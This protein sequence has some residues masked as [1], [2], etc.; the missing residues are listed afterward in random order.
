[1]IWLQLHSFPGI[2]SHLITIFFL[3]YVWSPEQICHTLFLCSHTVLPPSQQFPWANSYLSPKIQLSCQFSQPTFFNSIPPNLMSPK[4]L[5]RVR[6]LQSNSAEFAEYI[7]PDFPANKNAIN[8][9]SVL[10]LIEIQFPEE[11][12]YTFLFKFR[13]ETQ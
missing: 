3:E 9:A 13:V 6:T 11:D 1:M 7:V 8:Y 12:K 4:N 2:I 5:F 10:L